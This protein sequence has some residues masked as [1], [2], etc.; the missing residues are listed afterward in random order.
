MIDV[1]GGFL[2][3]KL[4]G[5]RYLTLCL[6]QQRIYTMTKKILFLVTSHTELGATGEKT[7]IWAEEFVLPYFKFRDEG[8]DITV[9]SPIGGALPF[10][11]GSIKAAGENKPVIE[12][13]LS[14]KLAQSVAGSALKAESISVSQFDA[15]FVPGGHGAMWDLPVHPHAI[16]IIEEAFAQQKIIASVCH[17]PA[18]LVGARRKDGRPIVEGRLVN[19]FTDAEEIARGLNGVVPFALESQLKKLGANFKGVANWQAFAVQDG[20]LITGQ[21]PASTE[22]VV[23]LVLQQLAGTAE[24]VA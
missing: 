8:F 17:G 22:K 5:D 1:T 24:K 7:G 10:D 13:F 15:V 18:V 19:S 6:Q 16:R 4:P 3:T 9:S 12:R 20:L 2:E 21:N 11:P 14:D 23:D